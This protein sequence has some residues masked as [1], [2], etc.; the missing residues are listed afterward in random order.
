[1]VLVQRTH[2]W[3]LATTWPLVTIHNPNSKG[4]TAFS[5]FQ[6]NRYKYGAYTYSGK[7]LIHKVEREN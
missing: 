2:V 3:F 6:G 4:P 7:E 5:D 1:M